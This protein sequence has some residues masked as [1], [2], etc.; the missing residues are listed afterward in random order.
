[1]A[2]KK[3]PESDSQHPPLTAGEATKITWYIARMAKRGL[4][5]DTVYQGDLERKIERL[6]DGA[7]TRAEK[8]A[9]QPKK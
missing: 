7:R 2:A 3:T 9:K 5:G 1:M 4:A 8:N 6:I